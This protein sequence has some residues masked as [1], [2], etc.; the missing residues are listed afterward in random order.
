MPILAKEKTQT[1]MTNSEKLRR[2]IQHINVDLFYCVQILGKNLSIQGEHSEKVILA[3]RDVGVEEYKAGSFG[4]L[5][6][7]GAIEIDG[8]DELIYNVTLTK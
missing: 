6:A 8:E 4:F 1:N 5:Y 3:L 7:K 2:L